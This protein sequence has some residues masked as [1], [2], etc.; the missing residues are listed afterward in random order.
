[1]NKEEQELFANTWS[2]QGY[3]VYFPDNVKIAFGAVAIHNSLRSRRVGCCSSPWGQV[4]SVE[5]QSGIV[6]GIYRNPRHD[7]NFAD[8]FV[9]HLQ[10]LG[11]YTNWM[12]IGDWNLTPDE[13]DIHCLFP[14]DHVIHFPRG[15]NG[16]S[17]STRWKGSRCIDWCAS[18]PSFC[19]ESI[20]LDDTCWSDHIMLT[21]TI[22]PQR[23]DLPAVVD[24]LD[25]SRPGDMPLD[26]W[27]TACAKLWEKDKSTQLVPRRPDEIQQCWDNFNKKLEKLLITVGNKSNSGQIR[28]KGSCPKSTKKPHR[29]SELYSRGHVSG[30]KASEIVG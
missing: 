29:H 5:M 2:P 4:I 11:R 16:L 12:A 28:P 24:T 20:Q 18:A 15:T 3:S 21:L 17:K 1:M 30:E 13:G 7:L 9:A 14:M 23:Y 6:S 10:A 27:A 26:D 22:Q 25:C 8:M 19:P